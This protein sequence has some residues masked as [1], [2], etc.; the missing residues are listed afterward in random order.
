[1]VWFFRGELL[2]FQ[3]IT[4]LHLSPLLS[5]APAAPPPPADAAPPAP[6][7]TPAAETVA[8]DDVTAVGPGGVTQ[9][10]RVLEGMDDGRC[11]RR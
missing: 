5:Q 1:M 8:E 3:G 2:N 6:A 4:H 9:R 7:E 10:W 11:R